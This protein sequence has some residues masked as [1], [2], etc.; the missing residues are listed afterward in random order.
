MSMYLCRRGLTEDPLVGILKS[1]WQLYMAN[2]LA[3]V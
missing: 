2:E 3:H 1:I